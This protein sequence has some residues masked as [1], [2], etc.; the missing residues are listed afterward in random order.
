MQ[1]SRLLVGSESL[2]P[3]KS[4]LRADLVAGGL[5]LHIGLSFSVME[6]D[7]ELIAQTEPTER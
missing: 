6:Q 5:N 3:S 2:A 7:L 4:K 1:L